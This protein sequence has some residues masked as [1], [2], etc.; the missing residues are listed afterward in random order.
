LLINASLD[1]ST[2]W[3]FSKPFG[4]LRPFSVRTCS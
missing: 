2:A 3:V 4:A 1:L